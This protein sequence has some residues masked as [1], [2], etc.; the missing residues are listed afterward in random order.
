M[1][2]Q[3]SVY[4]EA[5]PEDLEV[6]WREALAQHGFQLELYPGF[7]VSSWQ[8]GFVPMS[9]RMPESLAAAERYGTDPILTGCEL[10]I[11]L[12]EPSE[13]DPAGL[14]PVVA[15]LLSIAQVGVHFRSATGRTVAEFRALVL[16]AGAVAYA[17]DGALVDGQDEAY[18]VGENALSY[19]IEAADRYEAM[20]DL[21]DEEWRLDPFNSWAEYELAIQTLLAQM[22]AQEPT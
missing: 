5:L 14:P 16:S 22:D 19:A 17:T 7:A 20:P 18:H 13:H 6:R 9:L 3:I 2:I 8:G 11:A 12:V 21:R 1:S 10:D 15:S 4:A